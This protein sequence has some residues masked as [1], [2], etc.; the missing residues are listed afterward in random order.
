MFKIKKIILPD[1]NYVNKYTKIITILCIFYTLC[2]MYLFSKF[3]KSFTH[4]D[5]LLVY[6]IFFDI[7]LGFYS[8][9]IFWNP[10]ML[11]VAHYI[12]MFM[13]FIVLLSN[14][15]YIL[16]YYFSLFIVM[17]LVWKFNNNRCIFDKIN[18]EIEFMGKPIKSDVTLNYGYY[19][20]F[21][22][23]PLKIYLNLNK[24]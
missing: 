9:V 12:F 11:S 3:K 21:I 24:N 2:L 17:L 1:K 23:Y 18:W 15:N 22:L 5:K 8:S 16:Y 4:F 14:N 6:I 20:L 19:I 7:F 10:Y 13:F